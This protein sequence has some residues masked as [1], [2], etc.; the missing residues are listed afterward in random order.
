MHNS[1][2]DQQCII[3][4]NLSIYHII[5][6]CIYNNIILPKAIATFWNIVNFHWGADSGQDP[7]QDHPNHPRTVYIR[8]YHSPYPGR[9]FTFYVIN[10]LNYCDLPKFLTIWISTKNPPPPK[11]LTDFHI[12][13]IIHLDAHNVKQVNSYEQ[14]FESEALGRR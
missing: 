6:W 7:F 4:I 10:W 13:I 3:K 14:L 9:S 12:I 11:V 8:L 5:Y 2:P 1:W